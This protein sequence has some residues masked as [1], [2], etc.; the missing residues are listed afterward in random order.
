MPCIAQKG[1]GWKIRRSKGGL[2]P[3]LYSTLGAC[4][5]RVAQMERGKTI[6]KT[7]KR[8]VISAR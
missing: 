7:K 3:K 1:G 8:T 2:Y 5:K 6:A 4:K